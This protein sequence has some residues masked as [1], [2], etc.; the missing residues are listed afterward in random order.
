M[1]ALE[2]DEKSFLEKAAYVVTPGSVVFGLLYYFGSKYW[3]AYY[4]YFGVR[5]SELELS[6]QDY[7]LASPTAIF[8]PLWVMLAVGLVGVLAFR[9]AERKLAAPE[10]ASRR[11]R[12]CQV[13][14]GVGVALLLLSFPV[15]LEPVWWLRAVEF[16]LPPGWE[17]ELAPSFLVALGALLT[18]FAL[19]LRRGPERR[20]ERFWNIAEGLLLAAMV[21]IVFFVMARYADGV[22]RSQAHHDARYGAE[23]MTIALVHSRSRIEPTTPSVK[24]ADLGAAHAPYRFRCTG[25]LVLGKSST[26]YFLI[27][28]VPSNAGSLTMVLRDDADIRVEVLGNQ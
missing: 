20:R 24:C 27:S 6:P 18:M 14:G 9:S 5:V 3:D 17:R 2:A 22:G 15:F 8:L 21:M 7:L 28:Q 1:A 19:Y 11:R 10:A 26:R 23:T 25:F 16:L 4:R 12:A 13:L